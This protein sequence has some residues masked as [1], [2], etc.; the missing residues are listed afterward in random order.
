MLH[1]EKQSSEPLLHQAVVVG[2]ISTVRLLIQ[3]GADTTEFNSEGATP[4]HLSVGYASKVEAIAIDIVRCLLEAN[5]D[6]W[7]ALGEDKAVTKMGDEIPYPPIQIVFSSGNESMVRL[8]LPYIQ[9]QSEAQSAF[10]WAIDGTKNLEMI[11]AILDLGLMDINAHLNGHTPLFSACLRRDLNTISLL[12]GAGANTNIPTKHPAIAGA[13]TLHAL[14][15]PSYYGYFCEDESS[16]ERLRDCFKCIIAAGANVHQADCNGTTPLHIVQ[17][18]MAAHILIDAGMDVNAMNSEGEGPLHVAHSLDVIEVLV[19]QADINMRNR[20]GK[21]L[22]LKAVLFRTLRGGI[23]EVP[24]LEACLRLVELGADVTVIDHDGNSALHYL[25]KRRDLSTSHGVRLLNCLMERGVDPSLRNQRGDM[26]LHS[27]GRSRK[28]DIEIFLEITKSDINSVDSRGHALLFIIMSNRLHHPAEMEAIISTLAKAGARFDVIDQRGRTLL[29]AALQ[30]QGSNGNILRLLVD[31]GVDPKQADSSGNTLWH[32]AASQFSTGRVSPHLLRQMVAL[33][34][35]L[36]KTND[37]GRTPLHVMC[38]RDQWWLKDGIGASLEL[39]DCDQ[40]K[41]PDQTLFDYILE[42]SP[43][44]VNRKDHAGTTPLHLTSTFSSQITKKLLEA[45]ADAR[46][47]TREGMNVFH[48]AAKCRQSNTIGL[49][50]DWFRSSKTI[51][52]LHTSLNA[53]DDHGRSPLY[54]AC[55]SGHCSAVELLIMAGAKVQMEPYHGSALNG[56]ADFEQEEDNWQHHGGGYDEPYAYRAL[57]DHAGCLDITNRRRDCYHMAR[58]D[59]ILS[60][61]LSNTTTPSCDAID[62]AIDT[63]VRR[64]SDYTVEQLVRIRNSLGYK[65]NLASLMGNPDFSH[66]VHSLLRSR[67]HEAV[68]ACV[69]QHSPSHGELHAILIELAKGGDFQLLETL[70]TPQVV[71]SLME[72]SAWRSDTSGQNM[73]SLLIS[74]CE[75]EEPNLSVIQLLVSKGAKLDEPGLPADPRY[76]D[77]TGETPLHSV[78]KLG[79]RYWWLTE[80]ALPFMLEQ[81]VDLDVRDIGGHTPL[82][83]SLKGMCEPSWNSRTT[84]MFLRAGANPSSTDDSGMSSLSRAVGNKAVHKML[85]QYGAVSAV[86]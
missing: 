20:R 14:A 67:F 85:L 70:L 77:R 66:H 84:E 48:L 33:N 49:V 19:S 43:E 86:D 75:S 24:G 18:P 34:I 41:G 69:T 61:I 80:Q 76:W 6:P 71:L 63:A 31:H 79:H 68:P 40:V 1:S 83:T 59:H 12:L 22:F 25:A 50:L 52:D 45:D 65:G 38:E 35:D 29:H 23:R 21:T 72:R 37:I 51:E 27:L 53:K 42:Q 78:A 13:N 56:C 74:A 16:S 26:A 15:A 11:R 7:Q 58:I 81:K 8:F 46:L 36:R 57:I 73:A 17:S 60:L 64:Q 28:Q 55:T 5:A 32:E 62:K 10:L 54:Y 30:H 44:D 2:D 3:N 9:T 39:E 4:L 47:T 82:D